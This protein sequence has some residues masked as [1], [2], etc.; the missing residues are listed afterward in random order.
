M[1]IFKHPLTP[2]FKTLLLLSFLWCLPAFAFAWPSQVGATVSRCQIQYAPVT[3]PLTTFGLQSLWLN[4]AVPLG[5][6]CF[7]ITM[8]FKERRSPARSNMLSAWHSNGALALV[9]AITLVWGTAFMISLVE[10]ALLLKSDHDQG[11]G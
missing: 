9:L 10:S 7:H 6:F 3:I 5:L 4:A 1:A 2:K 11:F 8:F